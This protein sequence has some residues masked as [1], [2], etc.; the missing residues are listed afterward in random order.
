MNQRVHVVHVPHRW[1]ELEEELQGV[2]QL[3]VIGGVSECCLSLGLEF[4]GEKK[5]NLDVAQTFV[6]PR[7]TSF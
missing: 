4:Y 5:Y 7:V 6:L 3:R 2:N 1:Y